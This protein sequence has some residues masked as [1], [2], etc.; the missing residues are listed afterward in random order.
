MNIV[1]IKS[2][3]AHRIN[4]IKQLQLALAHYFQDNNKYPTAAQ[5]N[6]SLAPT[7]IAA[8]PTDPNGASYLYSTLGVGVTC[9][10]Y[11]LGAVLEDSSNPGLLTDADAGVSSKCTGG[12]NDF[13]GASTGCNSSG[14]DDQCYDVKP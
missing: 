2:R 5:F 9:S 3:D 7:Y 14:G 4:D 6:N 8:I 11:H 10:S 13:N 12:A 1:R